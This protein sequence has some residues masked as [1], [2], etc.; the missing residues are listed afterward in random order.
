[1]VSFQF[2]AIVL[3]AVGLV[4]YTIGGF[5]HFARHPKSLDAMLQIPFYINPFQRL[6][7]SQSGDFMRGVF[8][9]PKA[10]WWWFIGVPI[11]LTGFVLLVL[12][13]FPL[14]YVALN[15]VV[16]AI[17]LGA[18]ELIIRRRR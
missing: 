15:T 13:T 7:A 3:F 18:R 9:D 12:S 10:R 1:M 6:P 14:A 17:F 11:G 4:L 5:I 2:V 16:L 8:A